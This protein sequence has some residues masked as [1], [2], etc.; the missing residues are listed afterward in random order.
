M[1][2]SEYTLI[3]VIEKTL[4]RALQ[5]KVQRN[6]YEATFAG[7]RGTLKLETART[8]HYWAWKHYEEGADIQWNLAKYAEFAS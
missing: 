7:R 3:E 4:D 2:M 5:A 8:A 1:E 6:A